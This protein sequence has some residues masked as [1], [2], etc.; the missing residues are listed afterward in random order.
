[1]SNTNKK[2][3]KKSVGNI[4]EQV[5][6]K[7]VPVDKMDLFGVEAMNNAYMICHNVQ[8]SILILMFFTAMHAHLHS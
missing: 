6:E 5:E 4:E 1:M 7:E 8:V 3:K 2:K